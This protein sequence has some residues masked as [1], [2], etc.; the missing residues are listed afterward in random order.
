MTDLIR[1]AKRLV[2]VLEARDPVGVHRPLRVADQ[3]GRAH[4]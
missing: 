2:E 1:F 4:V 3:I